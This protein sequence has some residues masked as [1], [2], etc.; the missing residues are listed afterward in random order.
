MKEIIKNPIDKDLIERELNEERFIKNTNKGGNKI[1]TLSHHNAHHTM[2]EIGR[3]REISFRDA[4]GGTGNKVDI[5]SLDMAEKGYE[6]LIVYNPV[7]REI[8]GGYRFILGQQAFNKKTG[9]FDFSTSH[10][11]DFSDQ[12][13]TKFLP[14]TIE[15]GRLWVQPKY[16]SSKNKEKKI[17]ALMNILDGLGSLVTRYPEIKYF[18]GKVTMYPNYSKYARNILLSFMN[19]FFPNR[20]NL[21]LPKPGLLAEVD[22]KDFKSRFSP[23][24]NYQEGLKLLNKLLKEKKEYIPPLIN[25]YMNLTST[26]MTFGTARNLDFGG[27]EETAVMIT[28]HDIHQEIINRHIN[29]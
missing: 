8:M 19:R 10:Y 14:Y 4:G 5:D 29:Y 1:Y 13:K 23:S 26:M 17:Y 2:Q 25:I 22:D 18:F 3:L 12:M 7:D 28:L 11:F 27:V 20:L 15:L 16:Q 24:I 21:C 9:S 6:Q